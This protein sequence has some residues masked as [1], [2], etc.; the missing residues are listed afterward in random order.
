MEEFEGNKHYIRIDEENRVIKGFSDAFEKPK[1]GDIVINEKGG[2]HFR[3][4]FENRVNPPLKTDEGVPLYKYENGEA[5][6]R[7][8]EEIQA[9]I[10]ALPPSP[11]TTVER[12]EQLEKASGTGGK[13]GERGIA[14]RLDSLE[15]RISELEEKVSQ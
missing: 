2:R 10:D 4:P 1:E 12:V 5:K 3:L 15:D 8:Q 9:D 11:P 14:H 7:T 6:E 13:A